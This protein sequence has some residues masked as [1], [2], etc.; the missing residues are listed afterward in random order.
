MKKKHV[1]SNLGL[2]KHEQTVYLALINFGPQKAAQIAKNTGLHRPTIYQMLPLL[3]NRGLISEA[4]KGK[5][6]V[7]AAESPKKLDLLMKDFQDSFANLLPDLEHAFA[8]QNTKPIL[9]VLEGKHGITWIWEDLVHSLKKDDVYYRYDSKSGIEFGDKYLPRDYREVRNA[10]QLQRF[11]ITSPTLAK[12]MKPSLGRAV[13]IVPA[14]FGKFDF[15]VSVII[16]NNKV[17]YIDLNSETAL[18]IE[19][20]AIA[21]FQRVL[22]KI[23]YDALPR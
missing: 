17:A 16:Y 23:L 12:Q 13:K 14:S 1:L 15:G 19:N 3:K 8:G 18:L 21:D 11:V 5:Q 2:S 10:K 6:R 20:K 4:P 9:K 7:Y 22:F